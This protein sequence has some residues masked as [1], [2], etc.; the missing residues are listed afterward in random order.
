MA[1]VTT[2]CPPCF[3][4]LLDG[5]LPRQ[6]HRALTW[7]LDTR[8]FAHI[9]THGNTKWTVPELILLTL[10]WVW[11]ECPTLTGAFTH[12]RQLCQTLLGKVVL[13][14]YQGLAGALTT[15]TPTLMPLLWERLHQ[16]MAEIAGKHWRI[17]L[18][19]PL[20]V[21]GSR[22]TTPRT[23][24]NERAFNPSHYGHGRTARSRRKWKNK[25]RRKK[26]L[27]PVHPQIWLTLL[28]HMG[29][30]MPWAWKCG[31][32]NA[33]ERL[34]FRELLETQKFPGKTLFCGDAG[35][36]GYDLWQAMAGRG[37]HFLMR[38]GSNI[39]LL[40]R[41]GDVRQHGDLVH[42]WPNAVAAKKQPPL[43]L[44]LLKFQAGRRVIFAVTNVLAEGDLTVSQAKDLYLMRWGVEVQFR[45]LKQTFGR[46]KLRSR[47]PE[48]A[49]V[50]LEWSLLG[51]WLV[52]LLSA[53]E[54]I[55]AGLGPER[56]SVSV[57]VQIVR[58]AMSR[59]RPTS[60]QEE[61]RGAV[62]DTYKR[63]SKKAA[64]YRPKT[65]DKPST[66]RPMVMNASAEQKRKYRQLLR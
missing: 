50:E 41:L 43:A 44:R 48:R 55:P 59:G 22:T 49:Y 23:R 61:L 54:Q 37:H 6:L 12:S 29:L 30:K 57:A 1:K 38:V 31:P 45:S 5:D 13:K 63:R 15:W 64:R 53:S 46:G 58:D 65:K 39:R 52:Q 17:G 40:R 66:G 9:S 32:S 4:A 8:L 19:L 10:F 24:K 56:S 3:T 27:M 7:A 28:W 34:H 2:P 25:S 20:A 18:W 21:D 47:T 16:R 14:S 33:S 60:L 36:V 42:F 35:F 51:L 62:K 11:S 26:K